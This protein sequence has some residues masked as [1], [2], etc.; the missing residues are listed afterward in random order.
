MRPLVLPLLLLLSALALAGSASVRGG[1]EDGES[2]P[3]DPSLAET[4]SNFISHG[5]AGHVC[6]SWGDTHMMPFAGQSYF[7]VYNPNVLKLVYKKHTDPKQ[8][9]LLE[10]R[11]VYAQWGR[12]TVDND[13][14]MRC[15][16]D[17]IVVRNA[18][19]GQYPSMTVNGERFA[20]SRSSRRLPNGPNGHYSARDISSGGWF[21]MEINCGYCGSRCRSDT[22]MWG[23]RTHLS[24]VRATGNRIYGNAK[25]EADNALAWQLGGACGYRRDRQQP[26]RYVGSDLVSWGASDFVV[27]KSKHVELAKAT[28][29]VAD[30]A[31]LER[32]RN[33]CRAA[34][35]KATGIT[36]SKGL[37]DRFK[38]LDTD[39]ER[40]LKEFIQSC[41]VDNYFG[42][43][44]SVSDMRELV[45]DWVRLVKN[46]VRQ[47]LADELRKLRKCIFPSSPEAAKKLLREQ[48]E[49]SGFCGKQTAKPAPLPTLPPCDGQ[50]QTVLDTL[51]YATVDMSYLFNT[52]LKAMP[53]NRNILSRRRVPFD[54]GLTTGS[55][56]WHSHYGAAKQQNS[57]TVP[58]NEYNVVRVFT[59]I[60]S[61]WGSK[62]NRPL[63]WLTFVARS[64]DGKKR[65]Q[66]KVNL[67][68]NVNL[69]DHNMAT[70]TYTNKL[71]ADNAFEGWR[72][73]PHGIDIQTW[74]MPQ[75][76]ETMVLESVTL[77]DAGAT[78]VQRTFCAAISVEKGTRHAYKEL[79]IPYNFG[80]G[81][82]PRFAEERSG[83]AAAAGSQ[84]A[85][86]ADLAA[87]AAGTGG[88]VRFGPDYD[89]FRPSFQLSTDPGKN[90]WHSL[91]G[92][93]AGTKQ[94][95]IAV[96]QY[97][98]RNLYTLVSLAAGVANA[99]GISYIVVTGKHLD[100]SQ[101]A[102]HRFHVVGGVTARSGTRSNRY[103]NAISAVNA[104]S[105]FTGPNG[106][107]DMQTWPLPHEFHTQVLD[108]VQFVDNGAAGRQRM[109]VMGATVDF[110]RTEHKYDAIDISPTFNYALSPAP[111]GDITLGPNYENAMVPVVFGKNP[112]RNAW[113]TGASQ[114]QTTM[115]Y[116]IGKFG[117]SRVF[118]VMGLQY[119]RA[120]NY[121]LARIEFV[122]KYQDG[123]P[124]LRHTFTVA[125]NEEVRNWDY[126]NSKVPNRLQS[127]KAMNAWESQGK[128]LDMQTWELP[129]G[130]ANQVLDKVIVTDTG[131]T[132]VQRL[133]LAALTT[134]W[135]F[136]PV[137][138]EQIRLKAS[139]DFCV[140][141]A[142]Q[143]KP[144]VSLVLQLCKAESKPQR[145]EFFTDGS[146]RPAMDRRL[147]VTT[148]SDGK[149]ASASLFV[150]ACHAERASTQRWKWDDATSALHLHAHANYVLSLKAGAMLVGQPVHVYRYAERASSM[151][152]ERSD[153]KNPPKFPASVQLRYKMDQR[154]CAEAIPGNKVQLKRCRTNRR[155]QLFRFYPGDKTI[156]YAAR[157]R[158]LRYCIKPEGLKRNK[159]AVSLQT[160]HPAQS[161]PQEWKITASGHIGM[162]AGPR[163]GLDIGDG[164]TVGAEILKEPLVTLNLR[165]KATYTD[166][167]EK[168]V[169]TP[170]MGATRQR[171]EGLWV[172]SAP[173]A[174]A[175]DSLLKR[176]LAEEATALAQAKAQEAGI[177]RDAEAQR[178]QKVA[179]EAAKRSK[180]EA[181]QKAD[182]KR[183]AA[184]Q[185]EEKAEDASKKK[186]GDRLKAK[187]QEMGN[188][189]KAA[190]AARKK[191]AAAQAKAGKQAK[192]AI[193]AQAKAEQDEK[194]KF[195]ALKAAFAKQ[196]AAEAAQKKAT[197]EAAK[198]STKE[199]EQGI[200]AKVKEATEKSAK[201]AA[202]TAAAKK[203][204]AAASS[205]IDKAKSL[206]QAVKRN[207]KD[208]EIKMREEAEK[209]NSAHHAAAKALA[210]RKSQEEGGKRDLER[211][212]A[213]DSRAREQLT[214]KGGVSE[215]KLKSDVKASRAQLAKDRAVLD[216][217]AA[218]ISAKGKVQEAKWK[219]DVKR[220]E[221][222]QKIKRE[223]I[224]ADRAGVAQSK[225]E[226]KE[227]KKSDVKA[228]TM[229]LDIAEAAK[230]QAAVVKTLSPEE[231]AEVLA[232]TRQAERDAGVPEAQRTKDADDQTA[233]AK[234][235]AGGDTGAVAD[236][237]AATE[238][239]TPGE[240]LGKAIGGDAA[241]TENDG[242]DSSASSGEATPAA[243]PVPPDRQDVVRKYAQSPDEAKNSSGDSSS[244]T[245]C[246]QAGQTVVVANTELT[247]TDQQPCK[248]EGAATVAAA[249]ADSATESVPVANTVV[250]ASA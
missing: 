140:G 18:R 250:A 224:A 154:Y 164:N 11:Q 19:N 188:K 86:A 85:L 121:K 215:G 125:A 15:G 212:R 119:G 81:W 7:N 50:D 156:R 161:D 88:G 163:W 242:S 159:V 58:V 70:R 247:P 244:P 104:V 30:P 90:V 181:E 42:T 172:L 216:E 6:V 113:Y 182:A 217:E 230:E 61:Y 238:P 59:V 34:I 234:A 96:G 51:E 55:N 173:G 46:D 109:Y 93:K 211:R 194:A 126:K 183:L 204:E 239:A 171:N 237:K 26:N 53:T 221:S 202:D 206:E 232:V 209:M 192:A 110:E 24:W 48:H 137:K 189:E 89:L 43:R 12:N 246:Y 248:S 229:R 49:L 235:V 167:K 74:S 64:M 195:A 165:R 97:G 191:A 56:A 138:P 149:G 135:S 233:A 45:C 37:H 80:T 130:F 175:D 67:V 31:R 213:S 10:T 219:A 243:P 134:D 153:P 66:H 133:F 3:L 28:G 27:S 176:A 101:G 52:G 2:A 214:K 144:G 118:T 223:R 73:G 210:K 102:V 207:V 4:G 79:P 226:D 20:L 143:P 62:N 136:A 57:L 35:E 94:M 168:V 141:L 187:A 108:T 179:E 218:K 75:S 41:A 100:G 5:S 240:A 36:L 72:R 103:P 40:N 174:A 44:H 146:V 197:E 115:Q 185:A 13:F 222:E 249:N 142:A 95:T 199:T 170:T 114:A 54:F 177:K 201:A 169:S 131:S 106:R 160:C 122:G 117:V 228:E 107:V 184:K 8:Q 92:A 39:V 83:S 76:F 123:S 203:A 69:R 236:A 124:G 152:W 82:N 9:F 77:T 38:T 225:A 112:E 186:E 196:T 23:I 190:A 47:E 99:K 166:T 231:R 200:K 155:A 220:A 84:A 129:S 116:P 91:P 227:Q 29:A 132:G 127:I 148:D 22:Y 241:I 157:G 98:C 14:A 178:K 60:N 17:H 180:A 65:V 245:Q 162:D 198:K 208:A 68:G 78:G 105:V 32:E 128:A 158:D 25:V 205:K 21:M 33:Q 111:T 63:A 139:G 147:C 150:A 1:A 120:H 16:L 145:F 71:T 193:A 87:A 151:A